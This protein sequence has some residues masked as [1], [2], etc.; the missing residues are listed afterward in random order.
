MLENAIHGP[1]PQIVSR[2]AGNCDPS[3]LGWVFVLAVASP[4]AVE[5]PTLILQF[6]QNILYFHKL[7]LIMWCPARA[8]CLTPALNRVRYERRLK[9]IVRHLS[10]TFPIARL[11][12]QVHDC[13]DKK[14]PPLPRSTARHMGIYEPEPAGFHHQ[15][16]ARLVDTPPPVEL[17]NRPQRKG[18]IRGQAQY[19]HSIRPPH[20]V[21][22]RLQDGSDSSLR[23]VFP[24]LCKYVFSGNSFDCPGSDVVQ[25]LSRH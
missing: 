6:P 22:E 21:H 14:K 24:N 7:L 9:R 11:P 5:I 12:M 10:T 2:L 4:S 23:S 25:T 16:S 19:P 13:N 3:R 18:R 1:R 8:L 20:A 17:P 15:E